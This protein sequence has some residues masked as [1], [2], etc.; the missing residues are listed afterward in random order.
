MAIVEISALKAKFE[1]GDSP[2]SSDF[3]NLIDTLAALPEAGQAANG[4]AS[5]GTT[6]QVLVKV[7]ETNYN[8]QWVNQSGSATDDDQNILAN[9]VFG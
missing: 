2:K 8:T 9:Q 5:G 6:G 7:D 3:I 4:V 1:P